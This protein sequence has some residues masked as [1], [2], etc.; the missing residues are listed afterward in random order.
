ME[1][2]PPVP[3]PPHPPTTLTSPFYLL[4]PGTSPWYSIHTKIYASPSSTSPIS[5]TAW[6]TLVAFTNQILL[7][8]I[9]LSLTPRQMPDVLVVLKPYLEHRFPCLRN[10]KDGWQTIGVLQSR[11]KLLK[12]VPG[13]REREEERKKKEEKK[14]GKRRAEGPGE[15]GNGEAAADAVED[16]SGPATR[17]RARRTLEEEDAYDP[18]RRVRAAGPS[19][20]R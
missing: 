11:I 16:E 8:S 4:P 19:P 12:G 9:D 17:K 14:K 10:S 18:A 1:T 2:T 5:T 6:N 20:R 13:R 3:A 15:T 7:E